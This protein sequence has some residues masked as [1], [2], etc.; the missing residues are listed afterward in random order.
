MSHCFITSLF[1]YF[2]VEV[3]GNW[4]K[5]GKQGNYEKNL[6]NEAMKL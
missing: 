3:Q 4:G 2:F 6:S 5:F 1:H